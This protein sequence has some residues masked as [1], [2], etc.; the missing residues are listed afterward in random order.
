VFGHKSDNRSTKD[1]L[2]ISCALEAFHCEHQG[3]GF[4]ANSTLNDP[5]L[6]KQQ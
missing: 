3:P 1:P 5:D 6:D 2:Q 4:P